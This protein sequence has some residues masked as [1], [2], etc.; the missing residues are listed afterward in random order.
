MGSSMKIMAFAFS[1]TAIV[2]LAASIILSLSS[3]T[4]VGGNKAIIYDKKI[5]ATMQDISTRVPLGEGIITPNF[6]PI[7]MYFS[8]RVA[9]TPY[10]ANSYTSLLNIMNNK[11]Y[12]YLLVFEN[13]SDITGLIQTFRKENLP[14]L[15]RDFREIAT[16][17]T[18]FS[19]LHLYKRI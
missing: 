11:N 8:G 16:Y 18:D 17:T 3:G 7:V 5:I 1:A 9:Y 12:T 6:T 13:Q 10:S 19:R 15:A 2:I 4:D 14:N